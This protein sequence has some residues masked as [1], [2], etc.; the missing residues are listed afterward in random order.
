M[1]RMCGK[2]IGLGCFPSNSLESQSY[3][4]DEIAHMK[5]LYGVEN[6]K[7]KFLRKPK[8]AKFGRFLSFL[9]YF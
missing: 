6:S 4:F 3:D 1:S 7:K 2:G 5:P 8:K 9:D